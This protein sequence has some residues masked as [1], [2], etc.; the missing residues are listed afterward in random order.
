[1]RIL[2]IDPGARR[3]GLAT[4]DR[5]SGIATPWKTL[6]VRGRDDALKRLTDLILAGDFD[7][8]LVG[9]PLGADG[10]ERSAA[11]RARRFANE[12]TRRTGVRVVLRDEYASTH[13]AQERLA[14]VGSRRSVD[15]AAA[16]VILQ[17]YL[18]AEHSDS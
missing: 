14:D 15:E 12:L 2:A 10:E 4:A 17:E 16:A 9:L 7:L 8:L 6:Q 18:D 13:E 1:M 11:A 3:I 5:D